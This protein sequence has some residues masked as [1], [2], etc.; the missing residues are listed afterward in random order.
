VPFDLESVKEQ[1]VSLNPEGTIIV[2]SSLKGEGVNGW[3]DLLRG[4]L[5]T[6]RRALE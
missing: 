2:T 3:L 5:E 4:S 6:K 1:I